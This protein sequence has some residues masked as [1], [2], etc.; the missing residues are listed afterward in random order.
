[1]KRLLIVIAACVSMTVLAQT[2]EPKPTT[3]SKNRKGLIGNSMESKDAFY[4]MS[5]CGLG[6]VLFGE[7]ENRG[8]QILASTTNGIYSNSTFGM[9]SGTSNCVPDTSEH[10]AQVKKNMDMFVAANREALANDIVKNNGDTLT[11]M[12]E[13][14]GCSDKAYLGTK[15]QSRYETIFATKT[16]IEVSNNMFNT[17]TSDRYLVENCKL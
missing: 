7:T 10:A 8:G 11:A 1:M 14:M 3:K 4:G 9:S 15:L 2:V 13:I 5:G 12:S 16:D 6:S 17:V